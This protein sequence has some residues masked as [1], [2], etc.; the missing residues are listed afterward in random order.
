VDVRKALDE[1]FNR[2]APAMGT[3]IQRRLELRETP[4]VLASEEGLAHVFLNLLVNAAQ[5][6]PDSHPEP[7]IRVSLGT[8]GS[9][10]LVEIQDNGSGIEA[11]HLEHI[12]EPFY[13]TKPGGTG[14]GLS[15]CHGIITGFGGEIAVDSTPG[16]GTTFRVKLP[17]AT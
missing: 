11:E 2:A 1:A 3:R 5:A 10:V 8:Q 14:L 6:L 17:L 7:L 13:T 15:I 4:P 12:F 9:H 16:K